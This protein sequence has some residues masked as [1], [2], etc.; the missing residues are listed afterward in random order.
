MLIF[1]NF[2][3]F[4]IICAPSTLLKDVSLLDLT[5]RYQIE[6][7]HYDSIDRTLIENLDKIH[8]HIEKTWVSHRCEKPGCGSI[9]VCDG[10]MKPQRRICA[11]RLSGIRKFKTI[12][13]EVTLLIIICSENQKYFYVISK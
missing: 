7:S 12:P 9:L 10:G 6:I 3:D 4:L 8:A 1:T 11:S 13:G 2:S 5:R